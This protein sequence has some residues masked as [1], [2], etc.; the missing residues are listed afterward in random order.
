MRLY[1]ETL[2]PLGLIP[3]GSILSAPFA[4]QLGLQSK[5]LCFAFLELFGY[6]LGDGHLEGVNKTLGASTFLLTR[7]RITSIWNTSSSF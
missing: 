1:I 7:A 4:L 5:P 6:W 3:K 2:F